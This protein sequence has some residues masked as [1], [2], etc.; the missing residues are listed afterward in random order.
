MCMINTE[1][2]KVLLQEEKVRL[3]EELTSMGSIKN[4][5]GVW[6]ARPEAET[7]P[8]ADENDMADRGED[9]EL[10]SST[11]EILAKKLSAIETSLANIE[12]GTYGKCTVCG[13][14]IEEDRLEA[15]PS[16]QTCKSCM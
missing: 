4:E 13:N 9:F 3:E 7:A 14:D 2:Q 10:K 12:A 5:V 1:Q 15:N 6:V 16:A 8:E 11:T